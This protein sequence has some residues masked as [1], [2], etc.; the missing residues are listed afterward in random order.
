MKEVIKFKNYVKWYDEDD[1]P[2]NDETSIAEWM[3]E[4]FSYMLK[5]SPRYATDLRDVGNL[6]NDEWSAFASRFGDCSYYYFAE[7]TDAMAF[8]LRYF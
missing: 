7:E 5:L 4:R 8:K 2:E 1:S 3:N 6:T